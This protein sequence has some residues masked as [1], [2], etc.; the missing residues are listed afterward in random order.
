MQLF[1]SLYNYSLSEIFYPLKILAK[2]PLKQKFNQL[3]K[4]F[5]QFFACHISSSPISPSAAQRHKS[6]LVD[7]QHASQL[8]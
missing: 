5:Q 4:L 8:K 1:K 3:Q 2:N 6:N 7:F